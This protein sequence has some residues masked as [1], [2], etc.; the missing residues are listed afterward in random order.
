M[1]KKL[2]YLRE[3]EDLRREEYNIKCSSKAIF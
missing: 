3:L 2:C 1:H